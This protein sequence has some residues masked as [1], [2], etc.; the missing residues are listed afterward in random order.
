MRPTF[1]FFSAVILL[2]S[3]NN[4]DTTQVS[5]DHTTANKKE[6][7]VTRLDRPK[8]IEE[9]KRLKSLFS[10]KEKEKIAEIFQFPIP[11]T[12]VSIYIDDESYLMQ[13]KQNGDK[14]TRGMFNRFFPKIY[15]SL[16]MSEVN[17]LF[18]NIHLE[19]LRNQDSLGKEV[20]IKT[21]PCYK[22]YSI[23]VKN[24]IVTLTTGQGVNN[25]F[26]NSSTKED[27]VPENSSENCESVLWW[28]FRFDGKRL[29][30]EKIQGAG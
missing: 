3:C 22:F 9:L 28:V 21:E 1:L 29:I 14:T 15:E 17:Q 11:D 7:T 16:L 19:T 27:E 10:S 12:I 20:R 26:Q 18:S 25:D 6:S 8:L 30:L 2:Y 5:N 24:D 4:T 23:E 13:L